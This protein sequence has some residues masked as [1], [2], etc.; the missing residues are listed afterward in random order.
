MTRLRNRVAALESE[1]NHGSVHLWQRQGETADE[2]TARHFGPNGP[3]P[4]ILVVVY[5]WATSEAETVH[6][7][8]H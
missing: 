5:R 1:P 8:R 3:P 6:A 2:T 4:G 7:E